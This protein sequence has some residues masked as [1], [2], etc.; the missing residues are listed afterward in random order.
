MLL[1]KYCSITAVYT[2]A[3][4]STADQAAAAVIQLLL[5]QLRVTAA[6]KKIHPQLRL[7]ATVVIHY[8]RP[9]AVCLLLLIL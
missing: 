8:C 2:A 3:A 5:P 4:A 1:Q 9:S 7:A 6:A